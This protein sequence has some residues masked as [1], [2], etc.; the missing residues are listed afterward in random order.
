[1]TFNE[2][3]AL[4]MR[5]EQ[6]AEHEKNLAEQL[7]KEREIIFTR[8]KEIDELDF[9]CMKEQST[10]EKRDVPIAKSQYLN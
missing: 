6:L 3:N 9:Y 5:L 2:K 10:L 4:L 8:L 1:M 7:R